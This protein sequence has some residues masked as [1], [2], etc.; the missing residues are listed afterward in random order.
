MLLTMGTANVMVT[1]AITSNPNGRRQFRKMQ[2]L[3]GPHSTKELTE[4]V[5][6]HVIGLWCEIFGISPA[7]L[8]SAE[9]LV[10]RYVSSGMLDIL[11]HVEEFSPTGDVVALARGATII[12]QGVSAAIEALDSARNRA[13]KP[14]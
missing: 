10:L 7:D 9:R 13:C 3:L 8:N 1:D 5:R 11:G 6:S 4:L 14:Q 12:Q 2:A